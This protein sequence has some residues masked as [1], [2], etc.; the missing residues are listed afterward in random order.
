MSFSRQD[1]RVKNEGNF[2]SDKSVK[3]KVSLKD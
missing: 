2:Y 3:V 1:Y